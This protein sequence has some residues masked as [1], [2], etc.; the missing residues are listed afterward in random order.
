[1][2]G[3]YA[4]VADGD[5]GL[6]VFRLLTDKVMA[7]IPIGGGSISSTDGKVSLAFPPGAFSRAVNLTY[8]QLV[9]GEDPGALVN[10]RSNFYL[11]A[12]DADTGQTAALIPGQ[13]FTITVHYTNAEKGAMIEDTLALYYWNGTEWE[14]EATSVID[15][16]GNTVTATP[17]HFSLWAVLGETNKVYL[18]LVHQQ[19]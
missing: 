1:M 14:K 2:V 11:T 15:T 13:T 9:Y 12:T 19:E 5:G 18:P 7:S 8:R 16:A 17:D 6:I 3:N 10:I 4:Y